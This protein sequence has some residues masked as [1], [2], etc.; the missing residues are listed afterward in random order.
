M[1]YW[2]AAETER[3]ERLTVLL[4]KEEK[5]LIINIA[6]ARKSNMSDFVRNAILG[7]SFGGANHAA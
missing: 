4:T 5:Q 6:K 3:T 1:S 7:E 2:S